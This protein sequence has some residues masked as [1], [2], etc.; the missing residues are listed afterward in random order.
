[1][2]FQHRFTVHIDSIWRLGRGPKQVVSQVSLAISKTKN[3]QS[4]SELLPFDSGDMLDLSELDAYDNLLIEEAQDLCKTFSLTTKVRR[5]C[6]LDRMLWIKINSDECR[7]GADGV[8]CPDRMKGRL[9]P[10]EWKPIMA[11]F[12]G[13]Q[14]NT[15]K[16]YVSQLPH[17]LTRSFRG[18]PYRGRNL[19]PLRKLPELILPIVYSASRRSNSDQRDCSARKERRLEADVEVARVL[20]RDQFLEILGKIDGFGL[21][22][23]VKRTEKRGISRHFSGKPSVP[24]RIANFRAKT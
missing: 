18:V 4:N 21:D 14:E 20:G 11:L 7:F 13:V 23:V 19:D 2:G 8:F 1:M 5:V 22:D 3:W 10:E 6:W 12:L 9:E 16:E 24:E 17:C 15:S